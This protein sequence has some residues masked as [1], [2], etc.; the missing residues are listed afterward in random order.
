MSEAA[1]PDDEVTR[2]RAEVAALREQVAVSGS[3]TTPPPPTGRTGWWRTP[4]VAVLVVLGALMAPLSV[5]ATWAHDEIGDTDRYV[6]TVAPWPTIRRSRT[7]SP[8]SSRATS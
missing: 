2:L 7:R 5:V 8:T 3:A 1:D 6:D 4:L